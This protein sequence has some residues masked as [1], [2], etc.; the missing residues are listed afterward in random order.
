MFAQFLF[1]LI[2]VVA[3]ERQ[4]NTNRHLFKKA[5]FGFVT[6]N[7]LLVFGGFYDGLKFW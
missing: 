3:L 7:I 5:L 6:I 1:L 2:Q 4:Y